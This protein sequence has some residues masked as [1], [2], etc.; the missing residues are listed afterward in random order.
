M[1]VEDAFS[2]PY[3]RTFDGDYGLEWLGGDGGRV[4][5]RVAVGPALL[6]EHGAVHSGIFA[7]VAESLAS[8]GTATEVVPR[9][10]AA[11]GLSNSTHVLAEVRE[12]V[13]E[14]TGARR[15]RGDG[16]WLWDVEIRAGETLCA[17]A[18]VVIAVRAR[19]R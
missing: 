4:R 15:A 13:L 1:S 12:G 17:L 6:G 14:A 5:G 10:F 7:A 16:E 2:V 18:T 19:T 8:L 9:G 3:E 11:A